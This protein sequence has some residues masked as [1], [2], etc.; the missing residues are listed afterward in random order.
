[1]KFLTKF[2]R[3]RWRDQVIAVGKQLRYYES[4]RRNALYSDETHH[5]DAMIDHYTR[6]RD[7]LLTKLKETV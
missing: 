2:R 1:M 6:R 3:D 5:I 7:R 4:L